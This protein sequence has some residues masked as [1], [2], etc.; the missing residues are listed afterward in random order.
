MPTPRAHL[1][2][3][4]DGVFVYAIGGDT[5]QTNSGA[6][7]TMERYDPA[8][9]A[10][11]ALAP[12]PSPGSFIAA[13]VLN[14][15]IV[16]AGSGSA[17]SSATDVYDILGN[18]WR[19]APPMPGGRA[20]AAAGVANGGLYLVGGTVNGSPAYDTWSFTRRRAP[21]WKAGPAWDPCRPRARKPRRR[22]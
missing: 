2:V 20:L 6:V 4:T 19:S 3:V 22:S 11:S 14:G 9:N 1:A 10:W 12:M 8:T 13:G 16:V 7:A 21:V 5:T 15:A 17:N 18:T